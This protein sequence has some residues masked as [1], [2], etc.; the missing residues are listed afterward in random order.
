MTDVMVTTSEVIQNVARS[1]RAKRLVLDLSQQSLSEHSGVSLGVLKK[2]ERT[3]KISLESL[4]KLAFALGSLGDFTHVFK[5][6]SPEGFAT[7]DDLLKEKPRRR[8]RK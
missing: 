7:L 2:F 6:P 3:G 8:G 1:A 5:Q 4:L